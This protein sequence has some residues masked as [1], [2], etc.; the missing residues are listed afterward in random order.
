MAENAPSKMFRSIFKIMVATALVAGVHTLLAS[1]TAKTTA[2]TL[3]GER[4]RNA[5]YRP[6]YNIS[7]ITTFGA[8][9]LYG[10][11]LPDRELYLGFAEF[12]QS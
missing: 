6:F 8:L 12:Q 9:I 10:T 5:L 1:R 7:A 2:A 11:K 3:F 4:R